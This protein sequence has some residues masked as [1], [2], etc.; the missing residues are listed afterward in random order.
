M[1]RR[2]LEKIKL[3]LKSLLASRASE[4]CKVAVFVNGERLFEANLV[5]FS[6]TIPLRAWLPIDTNPKFKIVLDRQEI[7]L[8]VYK[9]ELVQS[10]RIVTG[11]PFRFFVDR[12][13]RQ[14]KRVS[15]SVEPGSV[16]PRHD[17][18]E[19]CNQSAA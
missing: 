1:V 4:P 17:I 6:R 12:K 16:Q 3:T 18:A 8:F 5:S 14:V 19:E 7:T 2:V 10:G 15:F 11:R 9:D 13:R